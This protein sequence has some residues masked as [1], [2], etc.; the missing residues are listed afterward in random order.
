MVLGELRGHVQNLVIVKLGGRLGN[1]LFSWAAGYA[2]ARRNNSQLLFYDPRGWVTPHDSLPSLIGSSFRLATPRQLI[3]M[4]H[5]SYPTPL[6]VTLR[7][8]CYEFTE[9]RASRSSHPRLLGDGADSIFRPNPLVLR[10]QPPVML[11]GSFQCEEYFANCADGVDSEIQLP[12]VP[13]L[14]VRRPVVSMTFRRGDYVSHGWNL[15]LSYYE[16]ALRHMTSEFDVGSVLLFC[17]DPEFLELAAKWLHGSTPVY[18]ATQFATDPIEQLAVMAA[19]DHH[20]LANSTFCWWGAWLGERRHQKESLVIAPKG[21]LGDDD[22][23]VPDRW[24]MVPTR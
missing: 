13:P 23:I 18:R 12:D 9:W 1:Q 24:T 22:G 10:A 11:Y 4:G 8:V 14:D 2:C 21:W 5:Y 20:I 7:D 16:N 6:A 17:D 15:P 19:C 3:R